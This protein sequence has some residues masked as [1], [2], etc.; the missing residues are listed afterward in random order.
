MEIF[1]RFISS[2]IN[3][4]KKKTMPKTLADQLSVTLIICACGWFLWVMDRHHINLVEKNL[5]RGSAA[6]CKQREQ[7]SATLADQLLVNSKILSMWVHSVGDK[8]ASYDIWSSSVGIHAV[9]KI[10]VVLSGRHRFYTFYTYSSRRLWE[11]RIQEKLVFGK[12]R[13]NDALQSPQERNCASSRDFHVRWPS[14]SVRLTCLNFRPV[15][16]VCAGC[17]LDPSSRH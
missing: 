17:G 11:T 13:I 1:L 2:I 9:T 14:G 12:Q 7:M 5:F 6:M 15:T 16:N 3:Q 8:H 10:S 4:S